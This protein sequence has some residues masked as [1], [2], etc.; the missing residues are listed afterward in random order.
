MRSP[1]NS[2]HNSQWKDFLWSHQ[3]MFH[4]LSYWTLLQLILLSFDEP[5]LYRIQFNMLKIPNLF[6]FRSIAQ[7]CFNQFISFQV[8]LLI[9]RDK[10][11]TLKSRCKK[12]PQSMSN[13]YHLISWIFTDEIIWLVLNLCGCGSPPR[14]LDVK[15][16]I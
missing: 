2:P 3:N 6:L 8:S 14:V 11:V 16:V 5:G 13:G 15:I 1:T 10:H 7:I 4:S 12:Y 9:F